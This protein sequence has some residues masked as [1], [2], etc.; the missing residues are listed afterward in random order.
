MKS[1]KTPRTTRHIPFTLPSW[2]P[3]EKKAVVDALSK[4]IGTGDGPYS[5]TMVSQ[6]SKILKTPFILPVTS[7]THAMECAIRALGIGPGDEVIVPSFTLSATANAVVLAGAKPVFADIED[8]TYGIDPVSVE[9]LIS[10]RTRAIMVVH[11]AGMPCRIDRILEI[12][13]KHKLYVVEDAAHCIGAYYRGKA[14]GTFGDAGAFSFHGT[15]NVCCGEG[16]ALVASNEKLLTTMDE[17]RVNGTNR[18]LYLKGLVDR[19]TWVRA[20][21]S[22]WLS[23]L[24]AAI[25]TAQL[26]KIPAINKKRA[27]IAKEFS[28][29]FAKFPHLCTLPRVPEGAN[30]NW[31]IY[32]LRFATKE[33]ADVFYDRMREAGIAVSTHYVPLHSSPFGRNLSGKQYR[34]LPVATRVYETLVRIPIY[35]G[36]TKRDITYITT[37]ARRVLSGL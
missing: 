29:T 8:E 30:P 22:Y 35:P 24:L 12:A 23:D 10:R 18:R 25:V 3:Q 37:T 2:G 4:T 6:L 15:K 31:H 34:E 5:D 20:G 28:K 11:Y 1:T 21:S 33:L 27:A 14:L 36:L 32:A 13:K 17:I 7:C 26:P 16:G 9:S 19:Y